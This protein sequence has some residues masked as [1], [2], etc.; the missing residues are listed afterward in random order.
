VRRLKTDPDISALVERMGVGSQLARAILLVDDEPFNLRVLRDLL[1]DRWRVHEA[2]SGAEALEI[3]AREPLDVV[4]ADQRMPG[5]TGVELL[6]E[7]R[8]RRPDI[9]GIVLTGYADMQALESAINRAH[10]F[11]FLRKPWEPADILQAVGQAGA[12]VEQR[13]TIERLVALLAQ[14]SDELKV[15]LE[16]LR[17]Q[18]EMLLHMERLGTI[19]RLS[20]GVAHDLANVVTGLRAVE[21]EMTQ[22]SASPELRRMV[23]LGLSH[24]DNLLRTLHTLREFSRAG[25]LEMKLLEVEPA[26]LV[27]DAIS[28]SRMDQL[29]KLRRVQSRVE[30]RLPRVRADRQKLTQVLVNLIRNALQATQNGTEVRITARALSPAE[31]EIAVEDDGPGVPPE[32]RAR[33]FQPFVSG[34]GEQGLGMGL[35]MARLVVDSHRGR[36]G[37]AD[38]PSGGARFEVV[39]PAVAAAGS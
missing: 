25:S 15:S 33:L 9:A 27:G 29:Y 28:I 22:A 5:M 23:N 35:Y 21:W 12:M 39:L 20:S 24:V 7:L 1:E 6:E 2:A 30:E 34:K 19:G 10:A 14:R 26:A 8:R 4:I 18:Q 13:R 16:A 37:A 38:R 17:S 31:V 32:L 3:A 11:R 36:I